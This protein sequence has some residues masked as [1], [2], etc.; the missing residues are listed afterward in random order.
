MAREHHHGR[1]TDRLSEW[2]ATLP[3]NTV[4]HGTLAAVVVLIASPLLLALL[5]STQ[6]PS[7]AADPT[8][9]W[10]GDQGLGKYAEAMTTYQLGRYIANSLVMAIL[11]TIGK[12]AI[13]LLAALALVYFRFPFKRLV[14]FFVLFAL[15]FPV[16]V[17]IVPLYE[18][19]ADLGWINS[20]AALTGPFIASA[21]AV[22]LL[23]QHLASIPDS[24]VETVKLDDIGPL[25]FL[26]RVL[27]P[28]SR[29]MLAGLAVINFV[30]A[31]NQYLWP[32]IVINEDARQVVQVGIRNLR[33]VQ[34]GGQLDWPLLMAGAVI[35]LLPPLVLLI[36]LRKPLL[37]TF[38][39]QTK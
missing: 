2:R 14:F 39:L 15:M 36:A 24:I 31:W 27:V 5:I 37:E 12:I 4:V 20:Y 28:M 17:R 30:Y 35:T 16:P 18:L 33:G 6:D 21:T 9:L 26:V 1:V 29:G 22:F 3:G 32:L 34:M 8:Y 7:Q 23:R 11:I 38:G 10:V 13:S 25:T 19:I